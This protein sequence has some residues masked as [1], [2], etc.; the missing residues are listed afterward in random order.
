MGDH[1]GLIILYCYIITVYLDMK[2]KARRD[3]VNLDIHSIPCEE[4]PVERGA[5]LMHA[6]RLEVA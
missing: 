4:Q 5:F 3:K 6:P 2:L 1:H